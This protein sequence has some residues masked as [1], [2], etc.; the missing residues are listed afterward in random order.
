MAPPSRG[1]SN[2]IAG[3]WGLIATAT[4]LIGVVEM[5]E[6][7]V[8]ANLLRVAIVVLMVV[9]AFLLVRYDLTKRQ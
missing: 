5:D 7:T 2:L 8:I 9:T 1:M 3:L 4:A 6:R